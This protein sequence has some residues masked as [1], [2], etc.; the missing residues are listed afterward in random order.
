MMNIER[1]SYGRLGAGIFLVIAGMVLMAAHF[2][3]FHTVPF[4]SFWPVILLAIGIGRLADAQNGH[5]YRKAFWMLFL[6]SW[7]LTCE[8]HLFGLWYHNAWPI[9]L[10]GVGIGM[11]WK[12]VYPARYRVA[13]ENSNGN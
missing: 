3:I 9:L 5:E 7:F 8:L 13:K 1:K 11:L 6:G 12:S 4:W 10:I 2:D